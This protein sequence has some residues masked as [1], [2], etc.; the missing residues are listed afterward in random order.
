MQTIRRVRDWWP[1]IR[2][3]RLAIGLSLAFVAAAL[4][5]SIGVLQ[6]TLYWI[7]T[8]LFG[9]LFFFT[10]SLPVSARLTKS[11]GRLRVPPVIA[12]AYLT[13]VASIILVLVD[14]MPLGFWWASL[15][16][17]NLGSIIPYG[18]GRLRARLAARN[19][20]GKIFRF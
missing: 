14:Q 6:T 2:F 20:R 12:L 5:L 18:V 19:A 9:L 4:W 3:D 10:G 8:G 11:Y 7:V 1:T 13:V 15:L 16:G 17:A